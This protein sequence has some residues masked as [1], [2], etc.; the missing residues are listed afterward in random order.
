MGAGR[1][2]FGTGLWNPFKYYY[3]VLSAWTCCA[4][5]SSFAAPTPRD[6]RS[7]IIG[8][9]LPVARP[10]LYHQGQRVPR[11][12]R[13]GLS[14]YAQ[15]MG[16]RRGCQCYPI[17][18]AGFRGQ[19]DCHAHVR[20]CPPIATS[21]SSQ[22]YQCVTSITKHVG[23]PA[24]L[25]TKHACR[26]VPGAAHIHNRHVSGQLAGASARPGALHACYT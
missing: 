14:R 9:V 18:C 7:S 6:E 22:P 25:C 5:S 16:A 1:D 12:R 4:C 17:L 13:V 20:P 24:C 2:A 8:L 10:M 3:L 26:S 21:M 15:L 19:P 23:V 11:L